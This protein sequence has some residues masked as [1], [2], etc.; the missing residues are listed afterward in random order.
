MGCVGEA[1]IAGKGVD[2]GHK[3]GV[4]RVVCVECVDDGCQAV[5]GAGGV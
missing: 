5:G 4:D 1:L 3:A 2:R